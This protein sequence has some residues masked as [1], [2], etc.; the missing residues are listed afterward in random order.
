M[1]VAN[2]QSDDNRTRANDDTNRKRGWWPYPRRRAAPERSMGACQSC[3][4]SAMLE[5]RPIAPAD[6]HGCG[7]DACS[8]VLEGVHAW[9]AHRSSWWPRLRSR[10][11]KADVVTRVEVLDEDSS[12][13]VY[14]LGSRVQHRGSRIWGQAIERPRFGISGLSRVQGLRDTLSRN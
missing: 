3:A 1:A 12:G 4:E 14:G 8:S 11:A 6:S 13:G 10:V 5:R 2:A 7:P 9:E